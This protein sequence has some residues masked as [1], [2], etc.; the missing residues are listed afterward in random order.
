MEEKELLPH[1][2]RVVV[3][4]QEL[5]DKISKLSPFIS[6]GVFQSLD[7]GEQGRLRVQ[8][9]IMQSYSDI[10]GQRVECF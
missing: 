9:A 3:E 10:L 5:D 2:Q 6:S 8:L 1:Q 4:K 7:K